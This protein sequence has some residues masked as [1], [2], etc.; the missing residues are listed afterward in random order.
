VHDAGHM[1]PMDQPRA[2]L[3]MITR[4]TRGI[5]LD[6]DLPVMQAVTDSSEL[7]MPAYTWNQ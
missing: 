7:V 2:S 3:E 4:F 5:P 1:V 6:F